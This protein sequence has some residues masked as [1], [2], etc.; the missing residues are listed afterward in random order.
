MMDHIT[1]VGIYLYRQSHYKP[2]GKTVN[3][4]MTRIKTS[5]SIE[6]KIWKEFKKKCIDADKQYSEVL[7]ELMK[8]FVNKSA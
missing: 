8:R 1:V 6:E 3:I 5:I 2:I 4:A 7:E